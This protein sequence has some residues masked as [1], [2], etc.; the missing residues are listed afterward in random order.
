MGK[1]IYLGCSLGIVASLLL[2][3][4]YICGVIVK[5]HLSKV[6]Q[7]NPKIEAFLTV[8]IIQYKVGYLNSKVELKIQAEKLGFSNKIITLNINNIPSFDLDHVA[9]G[10]VVEGN[11]NLS[12]ISSHLRYEIKLLS[13]G[14]IEGIFITDSFVV[15]VPF[16]KLN[17]EFGKN[18]V[19]FT[20]KNTRLSFILNTNHYQKM[21]DSKISLK[22]ENFILNSGDS[23]LQG[24]SSNFVLNFKKRSDG[25][26][27]LYPTFNFYDIG[28]HPPGT[29]MYIK[30]ISLGNFK[31][32][33]S[34]LK[35][36]YQNQVTFDW[37]KL[38]YNIQ[39]GSSM[40]SVEF[41]NLHIVEDKVRPGNKTS[42]LDIEDIKLEMFTHSNQFNF[43]QS[44]TIFQKL[45]LKNVV[46]SSEEAEYA[47]NVG[48]KQ[49]HLDICLKKPL[50]NV[51][52]DTIF[53]SS[54]DKLN[55]DIKT[56]NKSILDWKINHFNFGPLRFNSQ[57]LKLFHEA[58]KKNRGVHPLGRD[59]NDLQTITENVDAFLN[60]LHVQQKM[61]DYIQVPTTQFILSG[62]SMQTFWGNLQGSLK[63]YFDS[64]TPTN[65][66]FVDRFYHRVNE[67]DFYSDQIHLADKNHELF[68]LKPRMTS[69]QKRG[70]TDFN[71][72]IPEI[73]YSAL[74]SYFD[75]SRLHFNY[76]TRV[77]I[78]LSDVMVGAHTSFSQFMFKDKNIAKAVHL[79][80]DLKHWN[81]AAIKDYLIATQSGDNVDATK[82]SPEQEKTA[83]LVLLKSLLLSQPR[84]EMN[85][86]GELWSAPLQLQISADLDNDLSQ[87][88]KAGRLEDLTSSLLVQTATLH[89]KG[90]WREKLLDLLASDFSNEKLPT[91]LSLANYLQELIKQGLLQKDMNQNLICDLAISSSGIKLNNHLLNRVEQGELYMQLAMLMRETYDL[92]Y[93]PDPNEPNAEVLYH[94]GLMV[95]YGVGYN[96]DE[97]KGRMLIEQAALLG[98]TDAK[99]FIINHFSESMSL[100]NPKSLQKSLDSTNHEKKEFSDL[101][102]RKDS[103]SQI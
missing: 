41:S 25:A 89:I 55:I 44:Q 59:R 42:S 87:V 1:K 27:E 101:K 57:M 20:G 96:P 97:R 80:I 19:A 85:F 68:I 6:I 22:T 62:F 93:R 11:L 43:N 65:M 76:Y 15:K 99:V 37:N 92:S 79:N 60:T 95:F 8:K 100:K 35:K 39:M 40:P 7:S 34:D 73:K 31:M 52:I 28:I 10:N 47:A 49:F 71:I 16:F 91:E 38:Q 21:G 13:N 84:A 50:N 45:T 17:S 14:Q 70:M 64:T 63:N 36:I 98:S 29:H 33:L 61:V 67:S 86:S 53:S 58:S 103:I 81:L 75:L 74:N 3:S 77:P 88:Q 30:N 4:P 26:F 83:R 82:V 66:T 23:K 24:K 78:D 32:R 72:D 48:V 51:G 90:Q 18:G 12:P 5:S 2:A 102:N 9:W 69:R 54:F 94:K 56:N 46:L